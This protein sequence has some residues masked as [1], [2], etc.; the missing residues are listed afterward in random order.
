MKHCE[1]T[2]L[3]CTHARSHFLVQFLDGFL[4]GLP[5]FP[6]RDTLQLVCKHTL[7]FFS[8]YLCRFLLDRQAY[9]LVKS[10]DGVG[11]R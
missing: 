9:A 3:T 2:A 11:R 6:W 5:L 1:M 7:H 8:C 10:M 4:E